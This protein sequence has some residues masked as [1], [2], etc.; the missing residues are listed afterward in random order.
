MLQWVDESTKRRTTLRNTAQQ[1][2]G[3][4]Q[5]NV[6]QPGWIS[7]KK[8][9]LTHTCAHTHARVR[10]GLVKSGELLGLS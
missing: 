10:V 7:V 5:S 1:E 2:Q 6:Q 9:S 4:S 8:A 3:M